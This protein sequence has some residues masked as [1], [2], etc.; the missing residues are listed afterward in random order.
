MKGQAC[1]S[2]KGVHC[3][4]EGRWLPPVL[5]P[6]VWVQVHGDEVDTCTDVLVGHSL[7][8][9]I[10]V[11]GR[12]VQFEPDWKQVPGMVD[13]RA[14][15]RKVE[16][17]VFEAT[18]VRFDDEAGISYLRRDELPMNMVKELHFHLKKYALP[19]VDDNEPRRGYSYEEAIPL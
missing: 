14:L 11:N 7:D 2:L 19:P 8:K 6:I 5:V 13:V 12:L 9:L 4:W 3:S 1:D 16:G 10:A 18:A 17:E 15:H